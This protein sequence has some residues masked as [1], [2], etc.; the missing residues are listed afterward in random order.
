MSDL[1]IL[2]HSWLPWVILILSPP[3]KAE[4]STPVPTYVFAVYDLR[5]TDEISKVVR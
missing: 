1:A 2:Y 4:L 3:F 5:G